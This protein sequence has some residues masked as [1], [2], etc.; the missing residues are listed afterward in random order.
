MLLIALSLPAA[1]IR[2]EEEGVSFDQVPP[3]SFSPS[4]SLFMK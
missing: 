3:P 4:S 2:E 1:E